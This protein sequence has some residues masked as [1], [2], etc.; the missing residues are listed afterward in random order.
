MTFEQCPLDLKATVLGER[1]ETS[2][3]VAAAARSEVVALLVRRPVSLIVEAVVEAS[4]VQPG[5]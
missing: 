5:A 2:T 4:G 3:T 1:F